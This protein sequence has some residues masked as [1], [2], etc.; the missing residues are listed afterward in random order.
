[1]EARE[2]RNSWTIGPRTAGKHLERLKR[3]FNFCIENE[4]LE[5][6]P[7]RPLKTPKVSDT[8]VVPF[9]EDEVKK[10]LA[11][12]AKY[13]GPNR[14]RLKVLANLMLAIG[15]RIGDAV[16]IRKDRVMKTPDGYSIV[17]R[18]AKTGTHVSCPVPDK[19]AKSLLG[20]ADDTPFWTQRSSM[21][22]CASNWRKI[23]SRVFTAAGVGGH[24]HQFRHTFAKRLLVK[25][26]P[27]GF[28]A[29]LLGHGKVAI[30]EKFYSKWISERQAVVDTAVRGA[31]T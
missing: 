9:T 10:I 6:N 8:D 18:T 27:V 26:V 11:A 17:L 23:F 24:P 3:F 21:E 22:K 30:T 20:L 2:F 15:L 12:C 29:S 16:T 14:E 4:W 25:G 19:F 1:V 5:V 7:A 31:W 28:V 13:D